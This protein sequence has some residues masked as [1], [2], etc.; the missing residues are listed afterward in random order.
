[1]SC[2]S[3]APQVGSARFKSTRVV[4]VNRLK[5]NRCK[6]RPFCTPQHLN[7]NTHGLPNKRIFNAYFIST[8]AVWGSYLRFLCTIHFVREVPAVVVTVAPPRGLD[9]QAVLTLKLVGC[10]VHVVPCRQNITVMR[11]LRTSQMTDTLT[12]WNSIFLQNPVFV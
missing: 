11:G 4:K 6:T 9:T 12:P 5:A 2:D 8:E 1:M 10:A 7:G 3:D